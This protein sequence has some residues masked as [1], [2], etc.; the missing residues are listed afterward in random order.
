MVSAG[1]SN[2]IQTADEDA[3][4]TS[5]SYTGTLPLA[6]VFTSQGAQYAGMAKELLSRNAHFCSTIRELDAMLQALPA[7][8]RPSWT[9]EH[10]MLDSV[11]TSRVNDI[12]R[13]QPLCTAVQIALVSLLLSWGLSSPTAVVG[14]SSGEIV[15]A[16][17]AGLLTAKQAILVAYFRGYAVGQLRMKGAMMA[18]G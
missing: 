11:D 9:L 2:V 5:N 6:F 3:A 4:V 16:Y 13:S 1:F 7:R 12:E 17:A 18:V 10:I 15:A 8:Y 14:N